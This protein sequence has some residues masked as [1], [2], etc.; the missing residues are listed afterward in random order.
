MRIDLPFCNLKTCKYCA[1]GN[2]TDKNRYNG[3]D[4]A[5]LKDIEEAD[6][7]MQIKQEMASLGW[8]VEEKIAGEGWRENNGYTIWFRRSDWHGKFTY[9][10]TGNEVFF[11]GRTKNVHDYETILKTVKDTAEKAKKAWNDFPNSIPFQTAKG[12]VIEDVMIYP[13]EEG[14]DIK[15]IPKENRRRGR[16]DYD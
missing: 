6:E 1:D 5:R 9:T 4:Y 3:C 2:C 15:K 7:I 16:V 10:I 14:R 12:E 13:F 8:D 11:L